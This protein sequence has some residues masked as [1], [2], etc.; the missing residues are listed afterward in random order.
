VE[1]QLRPPTLIIVGKV[2]SL[3]HKLKWFVSED[4]RLAKS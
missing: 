4:D 2:V 1:A 3:H